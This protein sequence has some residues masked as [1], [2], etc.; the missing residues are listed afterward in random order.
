MG[1]QILYGHSQKVIWIHQPGG[2]RNDAVTVGV[3]IVGES[4]VVLILEVHQTRHAG[5]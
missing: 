2:G 5:K 4:D 3:W 1:D